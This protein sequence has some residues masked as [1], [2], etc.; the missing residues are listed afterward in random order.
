MTERLHFDFSLSCVA[1][2]KCVCESLSCAQLFVTPWTVA[3]QA[4]L[5]MGLLQE[6]IP[7][8]LPFPFPGDLPNPGIEPGSSAL[9]KDSLP[10]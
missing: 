9:Q 4:S 1:K 2:L 8:A 10:I 5:P 6:R 7:S 3:H